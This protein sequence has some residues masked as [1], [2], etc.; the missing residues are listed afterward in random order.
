MPGP[1]AIAAYQGGAAVA[2]YVA[3]HGVKKAAEKY[4]KQAVKK[5]A[6]KETAK[7]AATKGAIASG[8]GATARAVSNRRK[9]TQGN[10]GGLSD[11]QRETAVATGTAARRAFITAQ[12]EKR[13]EKRAAKKATQARPA[14]KRK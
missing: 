7:S 6:T 4:G 14:S 13:A 10:A 8:E 2:R 11:L 9:S 5:I 12:K 3:R 1:L